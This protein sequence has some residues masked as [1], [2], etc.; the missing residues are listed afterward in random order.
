MS[1]LMIE[2]FTGE[3]FLEV[4]DCNGEVGFCLSRD[5]DH[6]NDDAEPDMILI[7][8]HKFEWIIEEYLKAKGEMQ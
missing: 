5:E 2:F 3:G 8:K 7:P 1:K 6:D 4:R